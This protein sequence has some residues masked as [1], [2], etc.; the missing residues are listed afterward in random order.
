[1][2]EFEQHNIN[3]T[4]FFSL[5]GQSMYG[6][7]VNVVDGDTLVVI[8][9]LFDTYW[10][11]YVRLARIDTCET[12]SKNEELKEIAI[13]AK[14]C[15][16]EMITDFQLNEYSRKTILDYLDK[17]TCIVWLRCEEFDKFGRLLANVSKTKTSEIFSDVLIE[18]KL[19]YEYNGGKK[20]TE[21]E[22]LLLL[23]RTT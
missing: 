3:N 15:V 21:E 4:S 13:N 23:R 8:L 2:E 12:R 17:N 16:F 20:L 10:K 19:A 9:K 11:F 7:V 22:Q 14:K 6:R 1:M 5:Q 18:K